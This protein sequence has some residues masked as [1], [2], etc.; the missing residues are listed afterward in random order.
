LDPDIIAALDDDFDHEDPSNELE[1]NFI[2]LASGGVIPQEDIIE[3]EPNPEDL[4]GLFSSDEDESDYDDERADSLGSL[5]N[6]RLGGQGYDCDSSDDDDNKSRFTNY[7]M[8]SSVVRRNK[9]LLLV[10][11]RFEKVMSCYIIRSQFLNQIRIFT[12]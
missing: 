1:D 8:S 4:E 7:S 12:A 10:D 3:G 11:D 6:D 9:Q 5:K 2:E